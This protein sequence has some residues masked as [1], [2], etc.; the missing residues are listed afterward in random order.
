MNMSGLFTRNSR[1]VLAIWTL[2]AIAAIFSFLVLQIRSASG[3]E[4]LL[5]LPCRLFATYPI[6]PI[7]MAWK[8]I[9]SRK[10]TTHGSEDGRLE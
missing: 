6:A 1:E 8:W 9:L 2:P 5:K 3:S 7:I 4:N 10:E